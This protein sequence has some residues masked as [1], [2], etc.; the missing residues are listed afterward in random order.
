MVV[1]AGLA[2][3]PDVKGEVIMRLLAALLCGGLAACGSGSV[4]VPDDP[5]VLYEVPPSGSASTNGGDDFT[6]GSRGR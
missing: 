1:R 6:R 5:V 4:T 2:G 3:G